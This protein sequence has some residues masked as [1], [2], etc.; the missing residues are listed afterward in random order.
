MNLQQKDGKI[1]ITWRQEYEGAYQCNATHKNAQGDENAYITRL[2][3]FKSIYIILSKFIK[4]FIKILSKFIK[5][6]FI[7]N[8]NFILQLKIKVQRN[9]CISYDETVQHPQ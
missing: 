5:K 6:K 3:L 8:K 1:S 9:N 4:K 7:K 2:N